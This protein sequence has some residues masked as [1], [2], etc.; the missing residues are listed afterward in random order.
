VNAMEAE[1]VDVDSEDKRVLRS[2]S[3]F[4]ANWRL[5]AATQL[6]G[7]SQKAGEIV[8]GFLDLAPS[9]FQKSW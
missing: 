7:E 1:T 8:S 5:V 2:V 3:H 4:A 9:A 6:F